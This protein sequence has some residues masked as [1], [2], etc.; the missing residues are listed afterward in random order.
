MLPRRTPRSAVE[1]GFLVKADSLEELAGQAGIDPG[2]LRR[3]IERFNQFAATGRDEDF[4][5][6]ESVYDQYYGDP[7]VKP[8]PNL[9]P[10]G[11]PPFWATRIYPGD[12]GTK[13]GVLTDEHARAL[14]SD[15]TPIPGLYAA[16]NTTATVMGRTYPGPGGTIGPAMVFGYLAAKHLADRAPS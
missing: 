16:G 4:G 7:R 11:R 10:I 5:R 3:T 14:R 15:G 1:S 13:G 2:G 6:G 12:L 9:G 8:N